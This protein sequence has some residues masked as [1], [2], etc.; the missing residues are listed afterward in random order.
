MVSLPAVCVVAIAEG[1]DILIDS[2][3]ET[4]DVAVFVSCW[5]SQN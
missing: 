4:E 2:C 5:N 3:R 1:V